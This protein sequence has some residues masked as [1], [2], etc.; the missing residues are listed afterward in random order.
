[1]GRPRRAA[2]ISSSFCVQLKTLGDA[3]GLEGGR[4][5]TIMQAGFTIQRVSLPPVDGARV[6][7]RAIDT[8]L[9]PGDDFAATG[10]E[11]QLN[12]PDTYI[13]NPRSTVVLLA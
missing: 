7:R 1:L 11:I 4:L 12:P 6:W 13:V 8:S 10:R 2:T 3:V 9:A 5:F